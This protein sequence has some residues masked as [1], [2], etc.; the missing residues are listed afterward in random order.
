MLPGHAKTKQCTGS[1]DSTHIAFSF[2]GWHHSRLATPYCF[3]YQRR[4]PRG[5]SDR[6]RRPRLALRLR[7]GLRERLELRLRERLALRLLKLRL[8]LRLL[9]L[10]LRLRPRR[11][12]LLRLRL[13]L[14]KL[15]LRL[16]LRLK[17]RLKL[18][19]RLRLRRRN[20][21]G[22]RWRPLGGGLRRVLPPRKGDA[23]RRRKP[24]DLLLLRLRP[25]NGDAA[26]R[27][28]GR[29]G[30]DRARPL[31]GDGGRPERDAAACLAG[32]APRSSRRG[33]GAW[34][35]SSTAAAAASRTRSLTPSSQPSCMWLCARSASA[36]AANATVARLRGRSR[37]TRTTLPNLPK[38]SRR[39]SA[40]TLLSSSCNM[41]GEHVS[42]LLV[43]SNYTD[44]CGTAHAPREVVHAKREGLG[45]GDAAA[46]A[47]AARTYTIGRIDMGV[48]VS[49]RRDA[50]LHGERST[51]W[52][53]RESGSGGRDDAGE[54]SP[55]T[56][57]A[58]ETRSGRRREPSSFQSAILLFDSML[59]SCRVAT[60]RYSSK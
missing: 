38:I 7:L 43:I 9:R 16:R 49:L 53:E 37:S 21:L 52:R 18:R 40:F 39:W 22:E 26:R 2:S 57:S 35:R 12:L 11:K 25:R 44:C 29:D 46:L 51:Y 56:A 47:A 42:L 13:R 20:G 1:W 3:Q 55:P 45:G 41:E 5:D 36:A 15:R 34:G 19:L 27:G 30:G 6:R 54:T 4:G 8:R 24:G 60:S 48:D 14:R 28:A 10:R 17:L 59:F 33:G 32:G 31:P 50:G 23:T 58:T